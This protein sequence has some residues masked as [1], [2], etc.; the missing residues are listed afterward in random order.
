MRTTKLKR[1]IDHAKK[2][3]NRLSTRL[4]RCLAFEPLEQ[5]AL[6]TALGFG[7]IVF[8]GYQATTTDKVSFA[9]LAPISGITVLTVSDN[10]WTGSALATNE[11]NSVVTINGTFAAGT[12]FNLDLSRTAGLRW[13]VGTST[14]GITDAT[15]SGFA[16]NGSGDNL[17]AYNGTT[18]PNA[19][20]STSWV[21]AFAANNF[22]TTGSSTS[23]LTFLPSV[24]EAS[25]ASFSLGIANNTAN[26][27]AAYTGGNV[28]GTPSQIRSFVNVVSRWTTF[29]VAGG[30]TIPPTAIFTVQSGG[31]NQAPTGLALSNSSILE[32][33]GAAATIG[34]L[35]TTD[36]NAGDTF[37]YALVSGTGSTGNSSFNLNGNVLQATSSFDFESQNQYSVRIR[38]TDQGSLSFDQVFVIQVI[39]VEPEGPGSTTNLRIVSYNIA[40]SGGNGAPRAGLNTILEAIGSEV[41]AGIARRI[42][43][44]AIQEVAS[45]ATTSAAV[46]ALLNSLY[47]TTVYAFGTLNGSA[48]GAGT[49]GVVYNRQTLQLLGETRVG[50]A[51]SG[52]QERQTIRHWFQPVGA[53]ASTQFYV[54]NSH[55]KAGDDADGRDG[56]LTEAE[57]IRA[58][59]D[60]LGNDKNIIYVGDFNLYRSSEPAFGEIT[61]IGDGQAVDP[62]DRVGNWH[63]NASFVDIFTQ[64]PTIS[65]AGGFAG[66]GLDD[67]F[68]FQLVSTELTDTVGLD[69]R[70]GSYHT[71]G[72]NGT[73]PFNGDIND[74]ISTALTG[75]ANRL[76]VL[77]LLTTVSD[78][79]PVVVD[80]TLTTTP[81]DTTPPAILSVIAGGS[82]WLGPFIDAV[83]GGG[84]GGGNGL[85]IAITPN[86]TLTNT[87]IDRLYV[88]FSEPVFGFNA[89][90]INLFGASLSNY[91]GQISSV[92]YD[93]ANRRGIINLSSPISIDK[94]R[95]G[96]SSTIVDA[97]GNPLDGNGNGS[98]GGPLD[99]RF[100]ILVGDANGDGSVNGADLGLF[101]T[102]FNS[103][104]GTNNF[105]VRADWNSDGSVN[106]GDLSFFAANFNQSLPLTDPPPLTLGSASPE[107]EKRS[108]AAID[109]FFAS[110]LFADNCSTMDRSTIGVL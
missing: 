13:A 107:P 72:N 39:D 12:Q 15:T 19:G 10:A 73:A 71:F 33:A 16:L 65:N 55:W 8:T 37:T 57:R 46:A 3:R 79:L 63:N 100:N 2:M 34:S 26:E 31:N 20:T 18:P 77:N 59:A 97:A 22:L 86:V 25:N 102:A 21:A 48:T 23:Q 90:T 70:L 43:L 28:T 49:Q 92:A 7:D 35:T 96:V 36:P 56:R 76:T 93:S 68:D 17:F 108:L 54:Y 83:D 47:Q 53:A 14:I 29:T 32:N 9:L 38:T 44:L 69:Y 5:R 42:D 106:G 105:D 94:L 11:G 81:V 50:T 30:Q 82:T 109:E 84:I 103:S 61:S 27:N 78:H 88:Q 91:A 99:L 64:A 80:Y 95:L 104:G 24:F 40:S 52:G 4:R 58:D 6:L 85:G 101:S 62:A 75:L 87:G 110:T 98:A 41:V 66:G 51:G 1:G 45:Q 74:P 89:S 60:A 67:R